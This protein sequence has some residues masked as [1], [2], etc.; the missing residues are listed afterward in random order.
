MRR[1]LWSAIALAAAYQPTPKE[2]VYAEMRR[3]VGEFPAANHTSE[4]MVRSS[5]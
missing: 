1:L 4:A 2:R 5:A 3:Q